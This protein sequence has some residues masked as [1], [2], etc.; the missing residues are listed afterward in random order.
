MQVLM[1]LCKFCI[2]IGRKAIE[3]AGKF[4]K[5]APFLTIWNENWKIKHY[6]LNFC[7]KQN[8]K[9]NAP[10]S[11]LRSF[12]FNLFFLHWRFVVDLHTV[13]GFSL[14]C[15]ITG[16]HIPSYMVRTLIVLT[17]YYL[18]LSPFLLHILQCI[19]DRIVRSC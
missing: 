8:Q 13:H 15:S 18:V 5:S 10:T 1:H 7:A 2:K 12:V 16:K 3:Q 6:V 4:T 11:P 19:T 9:C 14:C 17:A